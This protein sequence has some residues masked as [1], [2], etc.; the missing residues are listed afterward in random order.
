M[1]KFLTLEVN[2]PLAELT[3]NEAPYEHEANYE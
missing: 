3:A 2:Y 1:Y